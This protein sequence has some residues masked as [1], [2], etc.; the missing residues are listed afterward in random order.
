MIS[1]S[2]THFKPFHKAFPARGRRPPALERRKSRPR[3]HT[4]ETENYMKLT[5]FRVISLTT[6][7]PGE[8][9]VRC[10]ARTDARR[11]GLD[12]RQLIFGDC[13]DEK[14]LFNDARR[15]AGRRR[16][17]LGR[18]QGDGH[19]WEPERDDCAAA[20]RAARGGGGHRAP[21]D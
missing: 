6:L 19:G 12:G 18:M 10:Y 11:P 4:K 13:K 16:A 17:A 15:R 14:A 2:I 21:R 9:F 20:A 8:C 7:P 1:A 3:N 5:L